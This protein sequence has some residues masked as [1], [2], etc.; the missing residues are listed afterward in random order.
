MS[1]QLGIQTILHDVGVF[2]VMQVAWMCMAQL[3]L[4]ELD[5]TV[6]HFA[7]A[8]ANVDHSVIIKLHCC[9]AIR[10]TH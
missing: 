2:A 8:V 1:Y 3:V 7:F 5:Y 4:K 10:A 9:V 6:L